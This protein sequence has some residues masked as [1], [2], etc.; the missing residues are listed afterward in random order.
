MHS[1]SAAGEPD[2][3]ALKSA[4]AANDATTL[5]VLACVVHDLA[6]PL[7]ALTSNLTVANELGAELAGSSAASELREVLQDIAASSEN[8]RRIVDD[9]RAFSRTAAEDSVSAEEALGVAR[10]LARATLARRCE[11]KPSLAPA[12]MLPGN[13]PIVVRAITRL[14][15]AMT[16][17]IAVERG[18]LRALTIEGIVASELGLL[19]QVRRDPFP[20]AAVR[21]IDAALAS[22]T[23]ARAELS[24]DGTNAAVR[25]TI[26]RQP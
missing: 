24:H 14:L 7:A 4:L 17:D 23:A 22:W 18:P 3:T 10:R 12:M 6:S 21:A 25:L 1:V 8:I 11:V 19:L 2:E 15:V 9:L 5:N 26:G 20:P 13:P 16:S